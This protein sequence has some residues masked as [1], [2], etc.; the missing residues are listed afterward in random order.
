[1]PWTNYPGCFHYFI[2]SVLFL[3]IE[4]FHP[5]RKVIYH[6]KARNDYKLEIEEKCVRNLG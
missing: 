2:L 5:N 3:A 6:Q 1:M 4:N